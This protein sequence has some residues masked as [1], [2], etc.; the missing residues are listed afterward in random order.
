MDK[1]TQTK[2][3]HHD[4]RLQAYIY[5]FMCVDTEKMAKEEYFPDN[6]KF[7]AN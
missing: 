7:V 5:D 3:F 6:E 4:L 2:N 1:Y